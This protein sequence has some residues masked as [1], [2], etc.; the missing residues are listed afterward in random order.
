VRNLDDGDPATRPWQGPPVAL[1]LE[2][3][4]SANWYLIRDEVV[5]ESRGRLAPGVQVR[6]MVRLGGPAEMIGSKQR[7]PSS[8]TCVIPRL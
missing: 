7:S 1:T 6:G 8:D 3:G 4:H 2:A 5:K